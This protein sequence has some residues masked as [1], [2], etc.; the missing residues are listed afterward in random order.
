MKKINYLMLTLLFF[1]TSCQTDTTI[2][3]EAVVVNEMSIAEDQT[4]VETKKEEQTKSTSTAT[5]PI[6]KQAA[7][8]KPK[9]DE[10][11]KKIAEQ[12]KK[13]SY[14]NEVKC[15]ETTQQQKEQ[16]CCKEVIDQY[17]KIYLS[18]DFKLS[19]KITTEDPIFNTCKKQKKWRLLIEE[20]ENQ[21]EDLI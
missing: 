19:T 5:V 10:E 12:Q 20:I 3:E 2:K 15:C 6:E 13:E 14:F 8:P 17:K 4:I 9:L 11:D 7:L 16:C 1:A 21:E 18:E